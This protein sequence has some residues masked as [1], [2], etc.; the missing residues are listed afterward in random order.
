MGEVEPGEIS[1]PEKL[2]PAHDLSQ[3][4]CGEPELDDWLRRRAPLNEE[5]GAS[6]TY[7]ICIGRQVVGYYALAAGAAAHRGA[8]GRVR[9]NMPDP[10]PV[11]VI[12]RLAVDLR[13]QGRGIGS[14]LLKEAVL[15]TVHAAE[16]AG[17]RA[18]LVHA[19]N[20]SAKRFYEKLGFVAS[21]TNP[22]TLMIT[23][24]AAAHTIAEKS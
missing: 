2:S 23:V 3:F 1:A 24:R 10:I 13:F 9:R 17:I 21:P 7:V 19:I 5:S 14:A 4:R 11:M 6:R 12:G 22:M 15:R 18:I 8:P 20:E 16:I